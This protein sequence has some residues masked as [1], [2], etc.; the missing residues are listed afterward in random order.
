MP[1]SSSSWPAWAGRSC[2]PDR[3][4]WMLMLRCRGLAR[5]LRRWRAQFTA[6]RYFALDGADYTT[7]KELDF[8]PFH[9]LRN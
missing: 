2:P 5:H 1:R 7:H 6:L 8:T 4:A 9:N 3:V